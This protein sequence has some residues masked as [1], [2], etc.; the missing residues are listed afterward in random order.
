MSSRLP[1]T[2]GC[3]QGALGRAFFLALV[4]RFAAGLPTP[5]MSLK[6]CRLPANTG[7]SA[8]AAHNSRMNWDVSGMEVFV[9]FIGVAVELQ[10]GYHRVAAPQGARHG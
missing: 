10:N 1:G 5:S 3:H 2:L 6:F 8:S 4:V 9:V 7:C